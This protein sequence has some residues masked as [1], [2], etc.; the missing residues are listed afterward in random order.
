[1]VCK[2][3]LQFL[4]I[5]LNPVSHVSDV[6]SVVFRKLHFPADCQHSA[7]ES[8]T[9]FVFQFI[10][11]KMSHNPNSGHGKIQKNISQNHID[12]PVISA[13][14]NDLIHKKTVQKGR[15]Q[16]QQHTDPL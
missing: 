2:K 5:H 6:I 11:A 16:S 13:F 15:G 10:V 9:Q 8:E 12:Q 1:M 7:F 14:H 3:A 4:F